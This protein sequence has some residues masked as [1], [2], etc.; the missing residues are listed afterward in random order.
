[1]QLFVNYQLKDWNS[2]SVFLLLIF[3][4]CIKISLKNVEATNHGEH[5]CIE[6][7]NTTNYI[8]YSQFVVWIDPLLTYII[9]F[10]KV[11]LD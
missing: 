4:T 2:I 1:M 7:S 6:S 8:Y 9:L 5:G 11:S 3:S 10:K